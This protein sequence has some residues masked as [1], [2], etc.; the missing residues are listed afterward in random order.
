MRASILVDRK[1]AVMLINALESTPMR[2]SWY[3]G[4]AWAG[5]EVCVHAVRLCTNVDESVCVAGSAL[6]S[7]RARGVK[8]LTSDVKS[9]G[10]EWHC[11]ALSGSFRLIIMSLP[12]AGASQPASQP[13]RQPGNQCGSLG[14]LIQALLP[15]GTL[16]PALWRQKHNRTEICGAAKEAGASAATHSGGAGRSHGRHQHQHHQQTLPGEGGIPDE[17]E[18]EGD[19]QWPKAVARDHV[20][21]F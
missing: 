2:S 6:V 12:R 11:I 8:P 14:A 16:A 7:T 1:A 18:L 13:A 20:W 21:A 5:S 10:R 4:G 15:L 19:M 3:Y 17:A 9:H